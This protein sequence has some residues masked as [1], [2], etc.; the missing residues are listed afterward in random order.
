M[1]QQYGFNIQQ[2]A[3]PSAPGAPEGLYND[4]AAGQTPGLAMPNMRMYSFIKYAYVLFYIHFTV[5]QNFEMFF[6]ETEIISHERLI[7][8]IHV[9]LN[10]GPL[11]L[12]MSSKFQHAGIKRGRVGKGSGPSVQNHKRL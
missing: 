9:V 3:I 4:P 11:T 2:P 7:L 10:D 1:A 8:G 6:R 5:C 12:Y